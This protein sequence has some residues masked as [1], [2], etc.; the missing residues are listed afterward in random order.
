MSPAEGFGPG[1]EHGPHAGLEPLVGGAP[2]ADAGFALIL[3]HGRGGT[4]A[5]MLPIARAARATD[6]ALIALVAADQS[7]YPN[8]FL[9]PRA[10]NEPWLGSALTSVDAAVDRVQAAGIPAARIL[11][12]GF[13]QGACLVLEYAANAAAARVRF[14]GV[15]AFS[16]ALIGDPAV[17][18]HDVGSLEGTPVLLA[19]GD[20]DVHIPEAVVRSSAER[21]RTLGAA[22]DLRI[23]PG[24]GHDI[25]GDQLQALADLAAALRGP[26]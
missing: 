16:G 7:W 19:C 11:L 18:R 9:S 8:R 22:V 20:A 14:G 12:V 3:V 1:A 15:A 4:A 2:L 24:V 21:F 13:S 10:E 17:P 26:Q 25:I 5:G 23:Y 6:A